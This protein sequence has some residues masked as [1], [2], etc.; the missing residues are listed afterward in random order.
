MPKHT[1]DTVEIESD[2]GTDH[3]C[4]PYE[5]A[6][7]SDTGGLTQ[8]GCFVETLPPGSASSI[9]H[10]HLSSDEMIYMLD[11]QVEVQEGAETYT[12]T[13]GEAVT[14]KAGVPAGH[15]LTNTSDAPARYLV[16]GSR[17]EDDTVTYP[18]A[19]RVLHVRRGPDGVVAE[20]RFTTLDGA[21]AT[22]PDEG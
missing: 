7:Y 20:R 17:V 14:F 11:G 10:W 19:D 22:A 18:D 15:C 13:P 3:P 8:F 1:P 9:K 16:V 6:Q 2:T 12:L 21:P 4:G 5:A